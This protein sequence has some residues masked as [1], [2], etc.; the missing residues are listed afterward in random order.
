VVVVFFCVA[1]Y[2]LCFGL[3]FGFWL[4]LYCCWVV[5][6]EVCLHFY[7]GFLGCGCGGVCQLIVGCLIVLVFLMKISGSEH[8]RGALKIVLTSKSFFILF[9][10]KF[11]ENKIGCVWHNMR[12][13]VH[14]STF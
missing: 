2:W 9:L 3:L 1:Q 5:G 13:S 11:V 7:V 10:E 6:G 14:R 12:P 4:V 8:F